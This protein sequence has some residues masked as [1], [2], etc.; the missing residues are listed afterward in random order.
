M[1]LSP[2]GG[3]YRRGTVPPRVI[4]THPLTSALPRQAG[5]GERASRPELRGVEFAATAVS[6]SEAITARLAGRGVLRPGVRRGRQRRRRVERGPCV[7]GR[8]ALASTLEERN[9]WN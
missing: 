2:W 8:R 7:L 4:G 9:A 1:V 3:K 6:Q 5:E